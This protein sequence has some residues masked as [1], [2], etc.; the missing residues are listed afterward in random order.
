[1][2]DAVTLFQILLAGPMSKDG[3]FAIKINKQSPTTKE[4]LAIRAQLDLLIDWWM[5]QDAIEADQSAL[6][7][8][9]GGE[10]GD[11]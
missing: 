5:E 2:S 4:L 11:V 3:R 10:D 8:T 9:Q 7:Q 1:M 6:V